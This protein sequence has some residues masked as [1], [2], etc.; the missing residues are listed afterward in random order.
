MYDK[1]IV[2]KLLSRLPFFKQ[3]FHRPMFYRPTIV[4]RVGE[5]CPLAILYGGAIFFFIKILQEFYPA[6]F[7]LFN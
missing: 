5:L 6:V 3:L 4:D 7:Y 1:G 2:V